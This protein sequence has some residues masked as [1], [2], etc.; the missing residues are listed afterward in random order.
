M[1]VYQGVVLLFFAMDKLIINELS[2]MAISVQFI[3]TKIVSLM[4]VSIE[5]YSIDEKIRNFNS[6]KGIQFYFKR[7]L[8]LTKTL[9]KEYEDINVNNGN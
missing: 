1:F 5:C 4:L 8:R 3:T 7:L 9:K 2:Q 6:G